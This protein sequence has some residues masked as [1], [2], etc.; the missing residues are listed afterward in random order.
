MEKRHRVTEPAPAD[1]CSMTTYRMDYRLVAV[2][3]CARRLGGSGLRPNSTPNV[4][5]K[6]FVVSVTL[7][8]KPI[9]L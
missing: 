3:L 8:R 9:V 1:D 5:H 4:T 7:A 6:S 2:S